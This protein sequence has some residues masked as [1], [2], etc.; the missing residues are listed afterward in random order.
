VKNSEDLNFL[1]FQNCGEVRDNGGAGR[2]WTFRGEFTMAWSELIYKSYRRAGRRDVQ[3][4]LLVAR[5]E[6]GRKGDAIVLRR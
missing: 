2:R 4:Y 1:L 3:A 6:F 5:R